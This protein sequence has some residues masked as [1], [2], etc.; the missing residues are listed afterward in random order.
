MWEKEKLLVMSNFSFS[1]CFQKPWTADKVKL[2]LVW[3]R[4]NDPVEGEKS[5]VKHGVKCKNLL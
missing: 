3:E 5:F 2:Q 1:Q 4:V